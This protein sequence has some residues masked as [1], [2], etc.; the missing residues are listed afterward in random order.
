MNTRFFIA[1]IQLSNRGLAKNYSAYC[2]DLPGCV[3]HGATEEKALA[4]LRS[5]LAQQIGRLGELGLEP[6]TPACTVKILQIG[7]PEE[8]QN[9]PEFANLNSMYVH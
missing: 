4:A 2:P 7:S 3:A 8:E 9:V 5:T 6:P 1:I